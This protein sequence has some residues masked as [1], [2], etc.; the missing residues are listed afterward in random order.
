MLPEAMAPIQ[1]SRAAVAQRCCAAF[2]SLPE[3]DKVKDKGAVQEQDELLAGF[4]RF[5]FFLTS[6]SK[7]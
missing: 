3:K 1:H 7:A 2:P 4:S 6:C 5:Y